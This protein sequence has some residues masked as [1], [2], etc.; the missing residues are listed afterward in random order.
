MVPTLVE[1]SKFFRVLVQLQFIKVY[2]EH[3]SATR[4]DY[5]RLCN[6]YIALVGTVDTQSLTPCW[7]A[8]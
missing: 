3:I 5:S 2:L 8:T 7:E 4:N 1:N 6:S